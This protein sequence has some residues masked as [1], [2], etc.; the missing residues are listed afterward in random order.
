MLQLRPRGGS[1]DRYYSPDRDLAHHGLNLYR[2][3]LVELEKHWQ[4]W[5]DYTPPTGEEM[6]TAVR[7]VAK[8]LSLVADP[9][10][11]DATAA[12]EKAGVF[13]VSRPALGVVMAQ[14]G[15]MQSAALFAA[16]RDV[17]PSPGR[18]TVTVADFEKTAEEVFHK[19]SKH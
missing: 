8:F 19:L 16:I 4:E 5:S 3:S 13:D 6:A 14:F 17:G 2:R 1:D 11:K 7:A 10:V 15:L 18:G 9:D 12:M